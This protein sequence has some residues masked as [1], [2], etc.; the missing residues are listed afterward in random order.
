MLPMWKPD[1]PLMIAGRPLSIQ[2]GWLVE[3]EE[4]FDE[5]CGGQLDPLWLSGLAATL[6]PL[7]MDRAPHVAARIAFVTLGYEPS[8]GATDDLLATLAPSSSSELH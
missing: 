2:D 3:F 1:R 4:I 8:R 6:Y 5:L 7:N